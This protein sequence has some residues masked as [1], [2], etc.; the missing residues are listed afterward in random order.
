MYFFSLGDFG[1]IEGFTGGQ[2]KNLAWIA[3]LIST[4]VLLL[5][6]MNMVIAIMSEKFAEV[7]QHSEL[8]MC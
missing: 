4:F 1:A 6:F 2:D 3:F 8:Y 5:L 7:G